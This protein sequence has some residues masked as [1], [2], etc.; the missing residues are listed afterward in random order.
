MPHPLLPALAPLAQACLALK[1]ALAGDLPRRLQLASEVHISCT[2][3]LL[4]AL[5]WA[6]VA[7]ACV[8]QEARRPPPLAP[9]LER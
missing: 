2:E 6:G 7:C 8:G 1:P 3:A 4:M 5:R 9:H